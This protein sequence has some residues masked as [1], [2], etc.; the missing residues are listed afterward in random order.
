MDSDKAF[1][2]T[3]GDRRW[4]RLAVGDLIEQLQN[5]DPRWTVHVYEGENC[6]VSVQ[7]H[8]GKEQGS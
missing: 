7:D 6:V 2:V 8:D 1:E 4:A 3:M 5:C